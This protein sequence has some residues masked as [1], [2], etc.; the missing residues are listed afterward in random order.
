MPAPR[1]IHSAQTLKAPRIIWECG[2]L[3][4]LFA[5]QG[6]SQLKEATQPSPERVPR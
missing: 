5:T 4:P 3:P 2:G 1:H 6:A